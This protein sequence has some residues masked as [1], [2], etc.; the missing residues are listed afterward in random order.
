MFAE[1]LPFAEKAYLLAPWY[2][3]SV[4]VFAGLLVRLRQPDRAT[5][6]RQTLGSGQ[7]YGAS[8][9]LALFYT[10][11]GDID[12]ATNVLFRSASVASARTQR[13]STEVLDHSTTTA[14]ALLSA[15]SM[16]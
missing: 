11:C 9:G 1:G 14:L 15:R 16:D 5:E 13:D 3:P 2:A 12:P 7:T 4:G 6:V 10:V 8:K